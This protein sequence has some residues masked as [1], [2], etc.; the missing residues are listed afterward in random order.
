MKG[1]AL[2]SVMLLVKAEFNAAVMTMLISVRFASVGLGIKESM[3]LCREVVIV[4]LS[5]PVLSS[6]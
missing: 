5:A 3:L 1:V 4:K 6:R 2:V